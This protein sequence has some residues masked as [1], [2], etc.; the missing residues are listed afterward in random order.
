M[1]Q[2]ENKTGKVVV[3][4]NGYLEA[5]EI[6]GF[7]LNRLSMLMPEVIIPVQNGLLEYPSLN[8]VNYTKWYRRDGSVIQEG[9][10]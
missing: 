4:A 2:F 9:R 10:F 6:D 3:D 1:L 8:E 5:Y 7:V